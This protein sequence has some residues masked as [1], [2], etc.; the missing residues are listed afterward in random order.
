M[1]HDDI[2]RILYVE[3]PS[4]KRITIEDVNVFFKYMFATM[5]QHGCH[6]GGV[7]PTNYPL[8]MVTQ[9]AITTDLRF[10]H[11]PLTFMVNQNIKLDPKYACK[12]DF[13]RTIKFY[14]RDK[15]VLRN[16]HV[17]ISTTYNPKNA[18][19]G[20]GYRDHTKE[21][22][23]ISKFLKKYDRYIQK[24]KVHKNGSTSIVLKKH[25]Q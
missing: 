14:K 20:F 3:P 24:I 13:E 9:P 2:N 17:A 11:D 21:K 5:K 6:L 18:E 1:M 22:H 25:A 19:G 8:T 12:M 16:N 15:K 4:A 23:E 10:I 7:Y